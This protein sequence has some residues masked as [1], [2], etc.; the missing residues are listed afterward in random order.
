MAMKFKDLLVQ[1]DGVLR[2]YNP[3]E[4][5]KLNEP[6]P[7]RNIAEGFEQFNLSSSDLVSF[8]EWKNGINEDIFCEIVDLGGP[9]SM[10]SVMNVRRNYS[11]PYDEAFIPI[12]SNGEDFLLYNTKPGGRQGM[13]YLYSAAML[14]IDRPISY[15]DSLESMIIATIAAYKNGIYKYNFEERHLDFDFKKLRDLKVSN[16]PN[17]MFWKKH[18]PLRPEEWYDI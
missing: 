17:S 6:L 13:I 15:Y 4:Y 8:Y 10:D 11:H 3:I 9:L 16:N 7:K 12:I 18:D 2:E 1:F 14:Y 5:Q